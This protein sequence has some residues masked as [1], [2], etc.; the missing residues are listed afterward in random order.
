MHLLAFPKANVGATATATVGYSVSRR[1]LQPTTF[2]QPVYAKKST[3]EPATGVHRRKQAS[4]GAW[5][6]IG[7][8]VVCFIQMTED[9][10]DDRNWLA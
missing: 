8:G 1:H 9:S 5:Q 2:E 6:T 3:V 10:N 7:V 4:L